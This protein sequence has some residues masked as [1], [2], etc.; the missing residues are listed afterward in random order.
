LVKVVEKY[1]LLL[2]LQEKT[3]VIHISTGLGLLVLVNLFVL[4][5][6]KVQ[7]VPQARTEVI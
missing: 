2:P 1:S 4:K 6:E 7:L 3:E 5:V